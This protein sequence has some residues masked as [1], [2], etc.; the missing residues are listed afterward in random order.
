MIVLATQK[1]MRLHR[2]LMQE[3]GGLGGL[4]DEGLF[5]PAVQGNFGTFGG[6]ELYP[7]MEEKTV[8]PHYSNKKSHQPFS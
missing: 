4:R 8:N 3:T 7:S 1:V 6:Q 5:D 2:F